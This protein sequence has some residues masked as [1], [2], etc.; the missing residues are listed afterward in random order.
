M[1]GDG[2]R[3]FRAYPARWAC[4]YPARAGLNVHTL[5]GGPVHTLHGLG[6]KERYAMQGSVCLPLSRTRC[7]YKS[8][9]DNRASSFQQSVS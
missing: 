4:A 9:E 7:E 6:M 5:H 8:D 1:R 2:S 3:P